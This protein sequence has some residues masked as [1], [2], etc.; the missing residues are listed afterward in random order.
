MKNILVTGGA[1]YVGSVLVEKLLKLKYHVRV[2]D[3]FIYDENSLNHIKDSNNLEIIKGDIRDAEVV[4]SVT[5]GMD[6]II[7]LASISNDPTAELNEELT[8]SVNYDAYKLLLKYSRQNGI[9]RFINASSSSVFG[10][11]D[12]ENITEELE[13]MPITIYSKYKAL[14]E[15]LVN[16]A[17]TDQFI[18]VNIRPATICGYSHRQRFDL[19][20]NVLTKDAITK[21]VITVNGGEQM[22]P[23][24]TMDDVTDLYIYMIDAD[25]KLING[26]T[27]N[28]GFENFKVIEI[29]EIIKKTLPFDVEIVIKPVI[30]QRN[31]HISSEKIIKQLGVKP[32]Y[33]IVD[34][35]KKLNQKFSEGEFENPEDEK[36]YNIKKMKETHFG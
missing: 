21:R 7:H 20:V 4:D 17:S 24:V 1:G 15:K 8:R 22:R 6:T 32:N 33:G 27:F 3:L 12:E 25:S 31:Y 13:P 35:V 30:D 18:T 10:M 26:E 19:T 2:I 9:N 28:F 11:R 34:M 29:A 16:D 5:K 23:N 36:Y 14:S